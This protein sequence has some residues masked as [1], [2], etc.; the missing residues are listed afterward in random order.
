M[1]CS[2]SINET[3]CCK[4]SA[5]Y[6]M[7]GKILAKSFWLRQ[8]FCYLSVGTPTHRK[9]CAPNTHTLG[10]RWA[11]RPSDADSVCRHSS[12]SA[13]FSLHVRGL[14]WDRGRARLH[15]VRPKARDVQIEQRR[16]EGREEENAFQGEARAS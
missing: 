8:A 3:G 2:K 4:I 7:L 13:F 16:E 9:A 15:L 6:T 12:P 11:S 10:S 5:F 1:S 14:L